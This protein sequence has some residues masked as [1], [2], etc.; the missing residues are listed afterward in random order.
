MSWLDVIVRVPRIDDLSCVWVANNNCTILRVVV[1]W[2]NF[3]IQS[4]LT[5]VNVSVVVQMS[6]HFLVQTNYIRRKGLDAVHQHL[7]V[8]IVNRSILE[9]FHAKIDPKKE[10]SRLSDDDIYKHI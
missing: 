1:I 8:V 7:P 3:E 10:P 6:L 2:Y 9:A 5:L 4:R